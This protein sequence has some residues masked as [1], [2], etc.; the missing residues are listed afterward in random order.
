MNLQLNKLQ[1]EDLAQF[2]ADM[3][4]AFQLGAEA[5]GDHYEEALPEAHIREGLEAENAQAYTAILDGKMVGGVILDFEK[6]NTTGYLV[7]I[8]V[9]ADLESKGIGRELWKL[10]ER[11]YPDISKWETF[12]PYSWKRNIHFYINVCGFQAVEFFNAHHSEN[13]PEHEGEEYF[14]FEKYTCN[15]N[16]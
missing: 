1:E 15:K 9:K 7:F 13:D 2:I 16:K 10:V 11:K 4:E 5:E 6:D 12:T 14:R 8:Y 3:Q